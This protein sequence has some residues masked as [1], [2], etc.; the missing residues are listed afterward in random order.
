MKNR[1]GVSKRVSLRDVAVRA[2]I[3]IATASS[4]LNG[5]NSNTR[6]SAETR[7]RVVEIAREMQYYPNAIGRALAGRPTHTLGVVVGLR[8]AKLDEADPFTFAVLEGIV[9][10]AAHATYNIMLFTNSWK[11]A[12]ES[13]GAVQDG[14]VDGVIVIAAS[15][16]SDILDALGKSG[17]PTVSLSASAGTSDIPVVDIDNEAGATL[18]T[19]HL[20]ELGHRK[21][22]HLSGD[23]NL[24]SAVVRQQTFLEVCAA[25][26]LAT[27]P[28]YVPSGTYEDVSGYER[29][30]TMLRLPDPPTAIFAAS[31]TLALAAIHAARDSGL[32]VPQDLSVI[33]F[34]D[35]PMSA[36][37]SP[38]LTTISQDLREIGMQAVQ[39]LVEI[40]SSGNAPSAPLLLTPT[41]IVRQSTAPP[42]S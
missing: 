37:V 36:L 39:T 7:K 9:A 25:A 38:P 33:G 21:I 16:N 31:D 4:V 2:G 20:I 15:N 18:A 17:M 12:N 28:E 8:R 30:L 23:V 42:A 41:L 22:A 27:P 14:R 3:G 10:A 35:D 1:P 11:S 19:Q 29:T 26:G 13:L 5:S 24:S 6:V 34:D 40:L 32:H